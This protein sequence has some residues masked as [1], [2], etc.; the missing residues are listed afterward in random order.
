[1]FLRIIGTLDLLKLLLRFL[2]RNLFRIVHFH[3]FFYVVAAAACDGTAIT[4]S[5]RDQ[6]IVPGTLPTF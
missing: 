3:F 2:K 5:A 1:M 4:T 6:E